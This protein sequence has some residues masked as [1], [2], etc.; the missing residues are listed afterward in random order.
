MTLLN[1]KN[2][3]SLMKLIIITIC[4][5]ALLSC[6]SDSEGRLGIEVPLGEDRV[7][8]INPYVVVGVVQD[9]PADRAGVK[10]DDIIVQ[11]DDRPTRGMAFDYL[12]NDH[13]LGKKGEPVTLVVERNGENYVF[14]I[15]RE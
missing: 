2:I 10:P 4:F 3:V 12:F 9:S 8:S 11:I 6:Q 15:V 13:L 5:A 7:S 1:I 14:Q